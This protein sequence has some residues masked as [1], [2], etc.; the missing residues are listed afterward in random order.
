MKTTL[1]NNTLA[2]LTLALMTWLVGMPSAS[3]VITTFQ[4]GEAGY[5]GQTD[6]YTEYQGGGS[7]FNYGGSLTMLVY[8]S[9]GSKKSAFVRWDMSSITSPVTVNS[10]SLSLFIT[11]PV[12]ATY[13][14]YPILRPGLNFGTADAAPQNGTVS[15][16]AAAY[17]PTTPVGWGSSNTGT[18]GPVSGQDYGTT[19]I[20]SFSVTPSTAGRLSFSLDAST[21]A[22]W[23][24][25]PSSN[26]G[27]VITAPGGVADQITIYTAETTI[28]TIPR[29]PILTFDYTAVPEPATATML[30]L[31]TLALGFHHSRSRRKFGDSL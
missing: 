29:V 18:Q 1:R 23:I 17:D 15:Y 19:S 8:E 27:F 21:V 2:G 12:T 25:S 22:S 31:A 24:N 9:S 5:T 14:L 13:N 6:A 4:Q 11:S 26:Y 16:S 30:G 28:Y 7:T 20:G 3:A 10:A